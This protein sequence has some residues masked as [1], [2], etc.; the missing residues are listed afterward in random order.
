MDPSLPVPALSDGPDLHLRPLRPSDAARVVEQ[1]VDGASV[2]WTTVP[3]PYGPADA[4]MF[5][6]TIAPQGWAD[7]SAATFAIELDG[8]FAGSLALRMLGAGRADV[9]YGLHPD[10]RGRRVMERAL[11]LVLDWGFADLGL[12]TV[13][14]EA[15]VGN[16]ASRRLA[17]RVGFSFDGTRRAWLDQRGT[18]RDAWSGTLHRDDP[19]EPRTPWLSCPPLD[20]G[21][22]LRLRR[23]DERD[24]DRVLEACTDERTAR[25]LGHLPHPYTRADAVA[26]VEGRERLHAEAIGETWAVVGVDDVLLGTVGWFGWEP[27]ERVEIG[28]WVHPDARGRGVA[29]AALRTVTA[30]AVETLGVARTEA[31]AAVGN[32]ASRAVIERCGYVAWGVESRGARV[33]AG[34]GERADLVHHTFTPGRSRP[35]GGDPVVTEQ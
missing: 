19:R 5:I 25:W 20:A 11:R 26:Y 2:R 32:A 6:D 23:L 28:Y 29:T 33:R 30:Y 17:W 4:A 1:C 14:W 13:L 8:R 27:G 35:G 31:C 21:E 10:A 34:S 9:G 3:A 15:F 7:G 18:L 24:V 22:G 12:Q 16:W